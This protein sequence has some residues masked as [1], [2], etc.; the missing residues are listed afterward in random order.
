M[1][2]TTSSSHVANIVTQNVALPKFCSLTSDTADLL[3]M[4]G[5]NY[6]HLAPVSKIQGFCV[7]LQFLS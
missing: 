6:M 7:S 1:G 3:L 5:S 2:V 4:R